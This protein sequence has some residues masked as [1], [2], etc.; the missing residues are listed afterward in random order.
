MDQ[1]TAQMLLLKCHGD[2]IWDT[3]ACLAAG[4]P[5]AWIAELTDRFESGFDSDRNSLYV[6]GR[7]VNQ[8]EGVSDLHLAYRL[9]EFIGIDWERVT[10]SAFSR[11]AKV[12]AIKAELD[13]M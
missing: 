7:L 1:V 9:A 4:I 5:E 8:F 11:R 3:T 10:Q 12:D 2:E 13:E 6:N